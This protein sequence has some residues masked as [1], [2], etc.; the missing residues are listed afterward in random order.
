MILAL[1]M[2]L[3]LATPGQEMTETEGQ[4]QTFA[5]RLKASAEKKKPEAIEDVEE[6]NEQQGT[7]RFQIRMTQTVA[8]RR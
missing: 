7:T 4:E 3:S 8:K 2:T 5:E 1:L 6:E